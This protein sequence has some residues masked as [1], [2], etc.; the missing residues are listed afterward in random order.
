MAAPDRTA[1]RRTLLAAP[2]LVPAAL[3]IALA[4]RSGG[5]STGSTA[6][7]ATELL[8]AIALWTIV[9]SAPLGGWSTALSLGLGSL[10]GL[11]A[12]TAASAAWSISPEL[13]LPEATR[14]VLYG[15]A[16]AFGGLVCADARRLRVLV[17][18]VVVAM[19]AL[20][21]MALASR[22]FPD[23][24]TASPGALPGRLSYPLGYSNALG[25]ASAIALILLVHITGADGA[26]SARVLAAAAVPLVVATLVETTSAGAA[27][28]GCA[29]VVLYTAMA[30]P[31]ALGAVL[32]VLAIPSGIAVWAVQGAPIDAPAAASPPLL[33]AAHEAGVLLLAAAVAAALLRVGALR[34]ERRA[35][36]RAPVRPRVVLL[37]LVLVLVLGAG[38]TTSVVDAGTGIRLHY[39]RVGADMLRAAP[40]QGGGAGAFALAWPRERERQAVARDAHSVLV[41]TA[42]ELGIVGLALLLAAFA[43][44][45][46]GLV[47]RAR[48]PGA[49]RAQRCV[50]LAVAAAWLLHAA[51]DWMWEQPAVTVPV[52][53]LTGAALARGTP[54]GDRAPPTRTLARAAAIVACGGLAITAGR[55]AL[56]SSDLEGSLRAARHGD[57][58]EAQARARKSLRLRP[59]SSAHVVLARCAMPSDPRAALAAID[60]AAARDPQNWRVHYDKAVVLAALGRDPRPEVGAAHALNLLEPRVSVALHRF[61]SSDPK[62]WRAEAQTLPFVLPS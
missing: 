23:V 61:A 35:A 1:L 40:F 9:A 24:L 36:P 50:L 26:R 22:T 3:G 18:A 34:L 56:A 2:G 12:W 15:A 33:G 55:L 62:V 21:L 44:L 58:V 6:L 47:E 30:R 16:L 32:A 28:A 4:F 31:P 52:L 27:G 5:Y 49:D 20:C 48:S 43:A 14:V 37:L 17:G 10:A 11:A 13:A 46:R 19:V 8:L 7:A 60:E 42:A 38:A 54:T 53:A 57:C 51:I 59:T 39:W 29:G 25:L 41:E 45:G